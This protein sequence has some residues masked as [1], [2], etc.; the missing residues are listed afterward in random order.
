MVIYKIIDTVLKI[1]KIIIIKKICAMKEL[2][3][4]RQVMLASFIILFAASCKKEN[5]NN[6]QCRIVTAVYTDGSTSEIYNITYNSSKKPSM[7]TASSGSNSSIR[8]ITYSGN[9][10]TSTNPDG[11]STLVTLNSNNT[12]DNIQEF[13]NASSTDWYN[14]KIVYD[15][16]GTPLKE[17]FSYARG[18]SIQTTIYT[19]SNGDIVSTYDGIETDTYE[20]YSDK[21]YQQGDFFGFFLSFLQYGVEGYR[22][23]TH[24]S[25]SL[26]S[27]GNSTPAE[28]TY[29]MNDKGMI[30]KVSILNITNPF[31]ITYQYECN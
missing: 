20:F 15:L 25:K 31:T 28:I 11:S 12:I 30:S 21:P 24:L 5:I 29:E 14:T 27:A 16:N 18:S 13:T 3:S 23:S 1:E 26:L 10:I 9:T 17:L 6:Q 22:K 2:F 19:V 7:I 4:K 8:T